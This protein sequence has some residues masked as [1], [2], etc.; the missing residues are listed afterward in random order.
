VGRPL[1]EAYALYRAA[2]ASLRTGDRATAR[3]S[4]VAGARLADGLGAGLLAGLIGRSARVAR[5]DLVGASPGATARDEEIA[6]SPT[7]AAIGLTPRE[8]EVLRYVG[9]GWSNREIAEA[10]EISRKTASVHVSNILGKLGVEN[11]TEA[12][13]VALRLGLVEETASGD[14][15]AEPAAVGRVEAAPEVLP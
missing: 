8:R 5:I 6:G 12:A 4:L 3:A 9:A 13:V 7:H 11:R 15:P 2:E 10:L 14:P 1:A